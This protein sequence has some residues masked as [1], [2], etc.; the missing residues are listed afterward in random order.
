MKTAP[1]SAVKSEKDKLYTLYM[2][3][4]YY[5]RAQKDACFVAADDKD[6]AVGYILCAPD[7][8]NYLANFKAHE[9]LDIRKLGFWY[10]LRASAE[11]RVQSRFQNE[12]IHVSNRASAL[13]LQAVFLEC[14]GAVV[15]PVYG[16]LAD[17]SLP[18]SFLAASAACLAG[19]LLF[20][21]WYKK[22]SA[23]S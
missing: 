12:E 21:F 19:Y 13:S 4:R 7:Y 14:T 6:R 18:I 1:A 16:C 17:I 20:L 10:F 23:G 8:Q 22:R 2:Y 11:M 3:N 15:S 5:T 9:L